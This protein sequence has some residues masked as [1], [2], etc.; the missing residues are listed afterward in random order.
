MAILTRDPFLI[1]PFRMADQLFGRMLGDVRQ[2]TG[3]LPTLDVRELP[4]E[5]VVLVDLPGV[6][7]E[8]VGIELSDQVLTISGSRVPY[9]EGEAKQVERPWGAFTRMLTVPQGIDPDSIWA[10]FAD[11][12]LTLHVPKPETAKPKKIA[13]GGGTG[14]KQLEH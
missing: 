3:F 2:T 7:S 5:Y 14:R 12:V 13:I 10:D 9:E 11:G 6:K 1:E 8:D 4:D